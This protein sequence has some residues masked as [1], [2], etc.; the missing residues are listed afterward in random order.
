MKRKACI[1]L[2]I[3]FFIIDYELK[4]LV[5]ESDLIPKIFKSL[6]LLNTIKTID[7]IDSNENSILFEYTELIN[8][9]LIKIKHNKNYRWNNIN[10]PHYIDKNSDISAIKCYI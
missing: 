7:W 5:I 2:M 8:K 4:K 10:F 1:T 6:N 9:I 3:I